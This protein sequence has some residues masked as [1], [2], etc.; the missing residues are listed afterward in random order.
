MW[1]KVVSWAVL[2]FLFVPLIQ[3]GSQLIQARLLGLGG[4]IWPNY[5]MI[6]N[7]CVVDPS[8]ASE[9]KAEVSDEDM[10]ALE[11]LGLGED[12]SSKNAAANSAPTSTQLELAQLATNLTWTQLAYCGVERRLSWLT[13]SAIDYIPMT[14]VVLLL[15]AGTVSTTR[16]YHIA[17]RNP[18]NSIEEKVT[19][20]S[21]ILANTIVLVSSAFMYPL[22]K[23]VEAQIQVLWILGL[24]LLSGLNI[25]NLKNPVFKS[26]EGKQNS[27][28]S[29]SLLCIP[30]YC[31]MA[32]VC[33]LYFF[34]YE[35]HPAGLAIYLQKLTAHATLYI[36]IGLYVWTGILLR[37]TSLG[38]RFFD[39]LKPWNLP[40]ELLAVIIVIVAALP[41]AYSGASGIVVLALGAT[42]FKE[43]RRAGAT[44]ERALAATAMSGSLGVVLPPCLLVV[45]VASL[46]L[47]V[48]T[49]ELFYWG[50]RV[51]AVSSTF[52]LIVSWFTRTESWKIRPQTGALSLTYQ[53][54]KSFGIYLFISIVIVLAIVL[55]LG[56]HFDEHTAP[57][58]LPIAML[59]L[60]SID[61]KISKKEKL[62]SGGAPVEEVHLS[63]TSYDAGSHLGA[64]LLLMGLSACMGGVFERSEVINL[65]PTHLGSPFSAMLILTFAL[66]IIGMLMDPYGAVILVSVTLY[67]IA[68]VNGIHPLNFWM[69]ALVSF[70]LGY[71]TPPV[72]LNHLLTKHVVREQLVEDPSL[73]SKG[74]FARHEH[75]IIPIIVLSLTLLITAFGPILYS[76]YSG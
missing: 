36:Q 74:F 27:K 20:F 43:L 39:L 10:A 29:N 48:T 32:I 3:S 53:A 7:V 72:A 59:A 63:H 51:F 21:Q 69:T 58:I 71:L 47:D 61:Y 62:Q 2:F 30:L 18:E 75:I 70:E 24:A 15:V 38:R 37:D 50:W 8:A 28:F 73:E 64:L 35:H 40:S 19:E 11:G 49:D 4:S 66:V 13:I 54:F 60:L 44:Q 57:Y 65:F 5:A 9:T 16:R 52:F 68:K 14:M 22:Q 17:L 76:N 45:I 34:L 26:G 12:T 42:I 1:R 23:G 41:T 67:P 31:W 56:T 55:G 6:R 46:N 25:Y 33:G